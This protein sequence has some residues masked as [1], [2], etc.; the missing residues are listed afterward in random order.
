MNFIVCAI[1]VQVSTTYGSWSWTLHFHS[2]SLSSMHLWGKYWQYFVEII[3]II[4]FEENQND[5]G[6]D[7]PAVVEEATGCHNGIAFPTETNCFLVVK[8]PQSIGGVIQLGFL[9]GTRTSSNITL[10]IHIIITHIRLVSFWKDSRPN[11]SHSNTILR[12][13]N[14]RSIPLIYIISSN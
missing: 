1:T 10:Y 3:Y 8:S 6:N 2:P 13:P 12:H 9:C 7:I 4:L 14:A 11:P 5:N